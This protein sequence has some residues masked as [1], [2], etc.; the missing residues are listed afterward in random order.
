MKSLVKLFMLTISIVLAVGLVAGCSRSF[1]SE[2]KEDV[3]VVPSSVPA[4]DN[5]GNG[6]VQ[7]NTEGAVAIEVEW[8]GE[9]NGS[10]LFNVAMNTHS[11]DLDQYDL[12][13]LAVLRDDAGNEYH[14]VSWE[15]VPG[16]HHR[17]G[18]LSFAAPDSL[19]LGK[20]KY[21][22]LIIRNID[23][24]EKRVLQWEL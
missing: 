18:S 10:L 22:E 13:E 16:G 21:F 9:S 23:G 12:A 5:P 8:L 24:I 14:A 20:I 3:S 1:V 15:S 7:S 17:Q 11:V 2:G 19:S 6:V 4:T